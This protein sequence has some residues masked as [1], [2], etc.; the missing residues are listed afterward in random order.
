MALSAIPAL[1][2][3]PDP[4]DLLP[5]ARLDKA[6]AAEIPSVSFRSLASG[7]WTAAFRAMRTSP[8]QIEVPA[9]GRRSAS[10][11]PEWHSPVAAECQPQFPRAQIWPRDLP[12][13]MK[14]EP[15]GTRS[16]AGGPPAPRP[17]RPGRTGRRD[18]MRK[19]RPVS[20]NTLTTK[21][22]SKET[23]AYQVFDHAQ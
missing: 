13:G 22:L 9:A 10:G 18:R 6:G 5:N 2:F 17:A 4:D 20:T 23:S 14:F 11:L 15:G 16:P 7:F 1:R 8:H 3:W 21:P 12:E 19:P